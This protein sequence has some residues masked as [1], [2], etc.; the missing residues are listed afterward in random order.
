M[1]KDVLDFWFTEPM[2]KYWFSSTETIDKNITEQYESLWEKAKTGQLDS[3]Q[4]TSQGCLSLCILLDQMPLNMFRGTAKSFSTE[5]QAVK[6]TKYAISEKLDLTIDHNQVAFLYMP[7]MHSENMVDQ[8]LSVE[9]FEKTKLIGNIRF[10][11]HHR[12]I[13]K[14]FGRFPHRNNVLN[15]KSTDSEIEYLTSKEAFTG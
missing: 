7:L 3:W 6:V 2:N 9:S 5:Q 13:V 1:I 12:D 4:E 14:K 10:S 15:R 11:T 8:N